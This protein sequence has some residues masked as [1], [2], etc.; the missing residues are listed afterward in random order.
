MW[1]DI[2][3]D[4]DFSLQ[5]IPFGVGSIGLSTRRCVSAVGDKVL[6]LGL[7][8]DAGAFADITNLNEN[9]FS[10]AS[11]D[12]YMAHDPEIWP[13][14]RQKIIDLFNGTSDLLR[15]NPELQQACMHDIHKVKMHLPCTIGD[16]TDF[17]SSREHATN[18]GIMF[19]GKENAL[20]P[21]WLHL[22][23][24][25]HGRSSTVQ[26]SGE[27]V[28]RP[29][30]QLQIDAA[31]PKKGSMYGPCKLLDFEL[32]M[33]FFVGGPP[34]SG[35]MS[36]DEAKKRIFGFCLMNDWSARDIQKWEYVPLGPFTAKDFATS[37][38]PWIVPTQALEPF[39]TATSA[40]VQDNPVPLEYL[41][42]PD[43]SSYNIELSVAIQSESMQKPTVICKSNFANLYW[44]AAQQ[45]VHHSVTGCKMNP[46]DLLASGTISG[47]TEEAYGSML[48][49]SWKGSKTIDLGGGEE[50]KFLK[51]GDLVIVEGFC[52]GEAGRVGF[53]VC[54]GKVLPA[55]TKTPPAVRE[56]QRYTDFKVYGYWRSSSSWRAR[57]ALTAK[58]VP[59]EVTSVN[60]K[61]G[62][63]KSAGFLEKN[64][65][66]K[67]PVLEYTETATGKVRRLTQSVAI[68]EFLDAI[69]PQKKSLIPK[70]QE[71]RVV[72]TE[73]VQVINSDIQPLQNAPLVK[74][75]EQDS[76]GKI[77]ATDFAKQ[78]IQDGLSMVATL[79]N[80]RKSEGSGHIGPYSMGSFAPTVVDACLIPQ[81]FNAR[82]WGVDVDKDFP[83]LAE[84]EKKC[85]VHPWFVPAHAS[86]QVDAET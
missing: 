23:V 47:Q 53:G 12:A 2:S 30:G 50:R 85:S 29:C 84:I 31:D 41:R 60:L 80:K 9:V 56:D 61:V 38:S 10:E 24:G 81:L 17:Y 27:P 66:G 42:D 44:N 11:L 62:E 8:Q 64:P 82:R 6:D 55:H 39:K 7:L 34:N 46:G 73:M 69:F 72:A 70:D 51:D 71:D 20:Q 67:V 58:R 86:K 32:E 33:A 16:Y 65:L 57:I 22:P 49:L 76:D 37:I 68:F 74:K 26:V 15:S 75:L 18:V 54:S 83:A 19:R 36:I 25:Y 21:N 40:G 52:A 79:I 13:E 14:V 4:S 59:Y 78:V 77:L 5:N 48:E 43:Y 28:V 1:F 63:Q 45:L 3:K 35:P